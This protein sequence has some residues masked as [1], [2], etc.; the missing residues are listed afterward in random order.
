M[1][2]VININD[3]KNAAKLW[4]LIKKEI[5]KS[6]ILEIEIEQEVIKIIEGFEVESLYTGILEIRIRCEKK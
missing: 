3:T 1:I 4:P 2:S 6:K 5:D